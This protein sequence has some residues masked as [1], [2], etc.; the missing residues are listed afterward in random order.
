M[1]DEKNMP[2]FGEML[3]T[4]QLSSNLTFTYNWIINVADEERNI[5]NG[6]FTT[7][8]KVGSYH[9][10]LLL[11]MK[12]T[13]TNGTAND[14]DL[15]TENVPRSVVR[16]FISVQS[17]GKTNITGGVCFLQYT[18]YCDDEMRLET[19]KFV[20]FLSNFFSL[21]NFFQIHRLKLLQ[22]HLLEEDPMKE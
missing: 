4:Q 1:M 22:H 18:T 7:N 11:R 6:S 10:Q 16:A 21:S 12:N 17:F 15:P 9:W 20:I 14:N 13:P 2:C 19:C 5:L 3:D 8:Y